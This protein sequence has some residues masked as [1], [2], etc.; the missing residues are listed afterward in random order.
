M[1]ELKLDLKKNPIQRWERKIDKREKQN[2]MKRLTCE[3][4][5][6]F[7]GVIIYI[8]RKNRVYICMY[9]CMYTHTYIHNR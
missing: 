7:N 8:V 3:K 1:E 6:M 4:I 9:V 5:D 2:R